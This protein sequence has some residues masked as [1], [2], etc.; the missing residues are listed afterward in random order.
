[1]DLINVNLKKSRNDSYDI[2]IGQ[3][4]MDHLGLMPDR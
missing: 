2:Y 4:A 3:G 1:M